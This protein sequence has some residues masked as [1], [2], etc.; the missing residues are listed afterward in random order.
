MSRHR[1]HELRYIWDVPT[2]APIGINQYVELNDLSLV[3]C[4]HI[5]PLNLPSNIN[6]EPRNNALL[7]SI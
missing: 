6:L 7:D 1:K 2:I 4:V 5:P 3:Y